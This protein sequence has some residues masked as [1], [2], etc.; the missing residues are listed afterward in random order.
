[1]STT[2]FAYLEAQNPE[3][4]SGW[5]CITHQDSF[6]GINFDNKELLPDITYSIPINDFRRLIRHLGYINDLKASQLSSKLH[7]EYEDLSKSAT[8]KPNNL[9]IYSISYYDLVKNYNQLVMGKQIADHTS[10]LNQ[11]VFQIMEQAV[12][13]RNA[14]MVNDMQ[15]LLQKS[16]RALPQDQSAEEK[17]LLDYLTVIIRRLANSYYFQLNIAGDQ[18]QLAPD[19]K[20]LIEVANEDMAKKVRLVSW[21]DN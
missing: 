12:I 3:A 14:Q 18:Y 15:K 7:V 4:P 13:D 6:D 11:Q 8:G 19:Q 5:T 10:N 16:M 21:M 2:F 17:Q 9:H 1:M 20:H